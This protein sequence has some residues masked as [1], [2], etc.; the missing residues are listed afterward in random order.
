MKKISS[1][2][3]DSLMWLW[4]F[5]QNLL[6][7]CIEGILCEA[8]YR[9]GIVRG[10]TIIYN[11]VLPTMSLGS[12]IFVNTMSTDTAVKHSHGHSKQS[13]IL[14]PLY[15]IVI[16]IPSLLH[17]IVYSICGRMGLSWNYYK[18]YTELWAN[19]LA[20]KS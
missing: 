11:Y 15:L 5:P 17:F 1:Y 9:E 20:E 7:I 13:R 16:G 6:A 12:Y 4:Q 8:A 14:G 18:F 3:K 2:I 19:K 10:N